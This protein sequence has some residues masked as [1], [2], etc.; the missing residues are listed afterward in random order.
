MEYIEEAIAKGNLFGLSERN[1]Y[2]ENPEFEGDLNFAP[3]YVWKNQDKFGYLLY[4]D[5]AILESI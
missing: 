1:V 3:D 4:P 2:L 5:D